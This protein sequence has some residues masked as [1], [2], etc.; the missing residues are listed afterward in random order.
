[1]FK[2]IKEFFSPKNFMKFQVFCELNQSLIFLGL[3]TIILF[4]AL[5]F[6]D[7]IVVV[8]GFTL[9]ADLFFLF[10]IPYLLG[11]LLVEILVFFFQYTGFLTFVIIIILWLLFFVYIVLCLSTLSCWRVI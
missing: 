4:C 5:I 8:I 11:L 9:W 6:F 10:F 1:M 3:N 7:F 2:K